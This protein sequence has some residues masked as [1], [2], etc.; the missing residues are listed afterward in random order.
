MATQAENALKAIAEKRRKRR[1]ELLDDI[2]KIDEEA[3]AERL[4][5]RKADQDRCTKAATEL[6][7]L[8]PEHTLNCTDT[9]RARNSEQCVRRF[10][11][12]TVKREAWV[13][14]DY[15]LQLILVKDTEDD[16]GG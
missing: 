9:D 7:K 10:L 16:N 4:A 6:L 15:V 13:D 1:Q 12:D 3:A 2:E 8:V 5:A 14:E 11:L